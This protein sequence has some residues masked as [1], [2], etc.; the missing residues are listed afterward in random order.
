MGSTPIGLSASRGA[1]ILGLS[2]WSTPFE[3]WQK[4][5]ESRQPGFNEKHGY[6]YPEYEESSV[7][8]WG[9]AFENSV[10]RLAEE[11]TGKKIKDREKLYSVEYSNLVDKIEDLDPI[12][13][14]HIDGWYGSGDT[15]PLHEGKT[16]GFFYYKDNF[17][18]PGTDKIPRIY[19]IQTQH[20]M[21]CTGADEVIVSVLVFPKSVDEWEKEGV[22]VKRNFS[23]GWFLHTENHIIS[24]NDWARVLYEMGYWATY[25]IKRNQP[26]INLMIKKYTAFW[27][28]HVLTGIPPKSQ[29]YDDIK[30]MTPEPVGTIIATPQLERW[31]VEYKEI[32]KET[33]DT[34]PLNKRRQQLKV[35]ILDWMRAQDSVIDDDSRERTL[36]MDS[37]GHKLIS[38]NGKVFR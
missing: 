14:C 1:A 19:Q 9:K 31:A 7:M 30:R 35:L 29:T 26:L 20:Q 18:K 17:G 28:D 4:I 38:F 27:K 33:S 10:I 2:K 15:E 32:G 34:G 3:V 37:R 6:K 24:I 12:I 8:R 36:L 16:A 25:P 13:T 11:A 21:L 22:E 23:G 5:S